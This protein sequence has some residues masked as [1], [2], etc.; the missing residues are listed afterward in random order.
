MV[1]IGR[2]S[3]RTRMVITSRLRFCDSEVEVASRDLQAKLVTSEISESIGD[4]LFLS[5]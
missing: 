2:I 4:S 1:Q 3:V 5:S